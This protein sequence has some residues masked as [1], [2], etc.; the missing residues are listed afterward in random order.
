MR[1]PLEANRARRSPPETSRPVS[2]PSCSSSVDSLVLDAAEIAP[3][4]DLAMAGAIIFATASRWDAQIVKGDVDL[5]GLP[6]V[7]LIRGDAS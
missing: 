2:R 3:G 5:H 4:P 7:T 1:L 6:S